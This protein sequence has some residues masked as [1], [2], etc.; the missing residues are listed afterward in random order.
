MYTTTI[1][2]IIFSTHFEPTITLN[3]VNLHRAPRSSPI[4]YRKSKQCFVSVNDKNKGDSYGEWRS[5][6]MAIVIVRVK[7][8]NM[9]MEWFKNK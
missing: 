8:N 1:I 9:V 3:P 6:R 7:A 5:E 2:I 4:S